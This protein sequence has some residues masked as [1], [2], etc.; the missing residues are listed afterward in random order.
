MPAAKV[1][2][3]GQVTV[4]IEVRR[5]MDLGPGSKLEFISGQDGTWRLSKK[6]CSIMELAGVLSYKDAPVSIEQMG[7]SARQHVVDAYFEG[8][9]D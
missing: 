1:T 9:K 4:P 7:K 8:I 3:K 5:E 6:K 2:S